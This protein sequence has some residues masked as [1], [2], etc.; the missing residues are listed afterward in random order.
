MTIPENILLQ[1]IHIVLPQI[2]NDRLSLRTKAGIRQAL[3]QGRWLTKAPVGYKNNKLT[4]LIEVDRLHA[5]IIVYCFQKMSTGAYTA[6][7]VRRMALEKGLKLSKQGF[8]HVLQNSVY[9]GKVKVP[10]TADEPLQLVEG[11]HEDSVLVTK[12]FFHYF[13]L[14][15]QL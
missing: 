8:I 10:A 13:Y 11:M 4:K 2:E 3:K 5:D 6:E 12:S 14:F 7:E 15:R 9:T 1:A